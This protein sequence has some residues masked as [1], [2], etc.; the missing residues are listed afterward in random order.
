VVDPTPHASAHVKVIR[1]DRHADR[2]A[3]DDQRPRQRGRKSKH[4]Q[5]RAFVKY[6]VGEEMDSHVESEQTASNITGGDEPT[7]AGCVVN[8]GR[9]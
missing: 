1:M 3:D 4:E 2:G 9:Y 8:E 7:Y 5:I 6:D